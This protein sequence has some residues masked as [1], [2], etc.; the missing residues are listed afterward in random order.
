MT[1]YTKLLTKLNLYIE[2]EYRVNLKTRSIKTNNWTKYL[3]NVIIKYYKIDYWAF[4]M[5]NR[6]KIKLSPDGTT[7]TQ[8]VDRDKRKRKGKISQ[9]LRNEYHNNFIQNSNFKSYLSKFQPV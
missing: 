8:A 5:E 4:D 7:V 3:T 2:H 6:N 9:F 1:E